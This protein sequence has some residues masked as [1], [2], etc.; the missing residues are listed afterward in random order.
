MR[1]LERVAILLASLA[2]SAGLIALLSGF[3]ASRDQGSLTGVH[4]PGA[5]FRDLGDARLEPGQQRPVYDSDPPTSGA[6]F[7]RP[8][9][10]DDGVLDDDQL[11]GALAAGDVV[12]FYGG[13]TPPPRLVALASSL[14]APF[15]SALAAAGQSVIL[16]RRRA[17]AG[18]I[19]AAWT[20]LLAAPNAADPQLRAFTAYWLGRGAALSR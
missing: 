16:A 14:A 10:H 17:T 12:I 4:A 1:L 7:A 18:L 2:L 15:T 20:R 13:R 9:E 19:A 3:F 6:H 5:A 8:V 11:L